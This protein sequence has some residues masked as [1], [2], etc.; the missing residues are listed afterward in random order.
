MSV[1]LKDRSAAA[2]HH[3][4][5]KNIS[6]KQLLLREQFQ[7]N[8]SFK[9]MFLCFLF[10]LL[11]LAQTACLPFLLPGLLLAVMLVKYKLRV[12]MNGFIIIT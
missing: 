8:Y 4:L 2:G 11:H 5:T 9:D 3:F 10:N 1:L 12:K 6:L 7:L